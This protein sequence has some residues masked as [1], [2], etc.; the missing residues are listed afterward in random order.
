MQ[1]TGEKY[2]EAR[3]AL[4][5]GSASAK[6][7]RWHY[8]P[9]W[10]EQGKRYEQLAASD[11]EEVAR[12]SVYSSLESVQ[13]LFTLTPFRLVASGKGPNGP[14]GWLA[15]RP[16]VETNARVVEASAPLA[17]V[18]FAS[19][20]ERSRRIVE[21]VLLLI[22]RWSAGASAR[23]REAAAARRST[24]GV[25]RRPARPVPVGTARRPWGDRSNELGHRSETAERDH[26]LR[27][28][29]DTRFR[30]AREGIADAELR[31]LVDAWIVDLQRNYEQLVE[32][33]PAAWARHVE[34]DFEAVVHGLGEQDDRGTNADWLIGLPSPTRIHVKESH[35]GDTAAT[36]PVATH[37][38]V[39]DES[40][41]P[42]PDGIAAL[43]GERW[44]IR[45]HRLTDGTI[46]P[47]HGTY[48]IESAAL[49]S[50]DTPQPRCRVSTH[51]PRAQ[52]A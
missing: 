28:P 7:Y 4:V 51:P 10:E 3:R 40:I 29:G 42:Q 21:R 26:F 45:G 31:S 6:R 1:Q 44:R 17:A 50:P 33:I 46:M 38:L 48:R 23:A 15:E 49:P 24:L 8:A 47:C 39:P 5:G 12:A 27:H 32:H 18:G 36:E 2:T 14:D 20:I 37:I 9:Y 41:S 25:M 22:D 34:F 35:K 43:A 16:A 19:E 11:G 30:A 13:L 52:S